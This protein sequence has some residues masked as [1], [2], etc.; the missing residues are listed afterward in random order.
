[1]SAGINVAGGKLDKVTGDQFSQRDFA[2]L[3]VADDRGGDAESWLELG[4]RRI[5]AGFLDE[6]A[7]KR[8]APP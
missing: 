7:V 2:C 6:N 4:G 5:G 1:M 3:A 8:L